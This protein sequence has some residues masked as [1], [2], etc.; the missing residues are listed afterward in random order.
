MNKERSSYKEEAQLA[1]AR[2]QWKR[3]LEN[4]Q[5]HC[6]EEPEDLRSSVKI[7]ELLERLGQKKEAVLVYRRAAESY[8]KDGFLLQAISL[9]KMIL[10][11]DPSAREVSDRVT[12]LYQKKIQ[13]PTPLQS[14]PPIPLFSELKERELRS[15]LQRVQVK[16]FSNGSFLCQEGE[17]GD[18]L[19]IITRGEV[20]VGKKTFKG[21]EVWIRNL[22]E[23]DFLGE[24]GFFTDQ[25]RHAT[26]KALTECEVLALTKAELD[27]MIKT[28]PRVREVLNSFFRQRV[29][30][31]FF[32]L[33]PLFSHLSPKEREEVFG[34]FQIRKFPAETLLFRAGD[35]PGPLYLVKN[36]EVEIFTE[37]REGKKVKFAAVGS[38]N[39][40]GEIGPLFKKPRMASA[41]TTRPTELL[42]LAEEDLEQFVNRFPSL[43]SALREISMKR[44]TRMKEI[45]SRKGV[46]KAKEALV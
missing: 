21:K 15:L 22:R 1:L 29:L 45:L 46:E 16:S 33:S 24:F 37:N 9:N 31:T 40:F 20:E 4:Y 11:I 39:F 38:G 27:Q 12:E 8:A 7:G 13:E 36:G 43:H 35:P 5:R 17:E 2:G 28:Y 18:S 44:L 32:V 19:M 3:A 41:K 34:R 42:E 23:G 6:A 10:R 30:D 26:V 14:I 25:K